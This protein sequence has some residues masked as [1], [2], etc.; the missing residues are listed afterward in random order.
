MEALILLVIGV[1]AMPILLMVVSQ[2]LC[3]LQT[4]A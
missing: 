1:I 3:K 2:I 4:V